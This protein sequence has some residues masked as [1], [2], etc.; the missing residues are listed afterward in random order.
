MLQRMIILVLMLKGYLLA[1][2]E[3]SPTS[4]KLVG[5]DGVTR[6]DSSQHV[7]K[8]I[9][10]SYYTLSSTPNFTVNMTTTAAI[11]SG[12]YIGWIY[13]H[14]TYTYTISRTTI[15]S[16]VVSVPMVFVKIPS[17]NYSF[18]DY[19]IPVHG[20]VILR[21]DTISNINGT[22]ITANIPYL[23]TL[24]VT[25]TDTQI[26][27]T[28][29]HTLS[30]IFVNTSTFNTLRFNNPTGNVAVINSSTI[31]TQIAGSATAYN[32]ATGTMNLIIKELVW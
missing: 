4:V 19:Y 32:T 11:L 29:K 16:G 9:G 7:A 23:A 31:G 18:G 1:S 3:I 26:F 17:I 5:S 8:M 28:V 2:F 24:S 10:A 14:E 13:G 6:I 20:S 15:P 30:S 21:T 12:T 27:I 22:A 25:Y